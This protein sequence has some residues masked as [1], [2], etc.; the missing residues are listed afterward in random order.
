M[1]ESLSIRDFQR[2]KRLT[3]KFSRNV[4][5]IVGRSDAGKSAILRA[6]GWV[7]R[8]R[9]AGAAFVRRRAAR[10]KVALTV[11]GRIVV[12]Q[13]GKGN[14]YSL[15]GRRFVSFGNAVPD[16]IADLLNVADVNFQSQHD[17]PYLLAQSPGQVAKALNSVINL[18]IIDRS[19]ARA[20][21]AVR[22][23]TTEIAVTRGRL[24]KSKSDATSLAWTPDFVKGVERLE[25]AANQIA[26][27]RTTI[28]SL[29]S[30]IERLE[31]AQARAKNAAPAILDGQKIER[32]GKRWLANRERL[33]SLG[34]LIDRIEAA[35]VRHAKLE[36]QANRLA[37]ELKRRTKG[38]CPICKRPI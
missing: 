7:C 12:R 3:I 35:Q 8:N 22:K 13:R 9:P 23:T 28:D 26:A 24:K 36:R 29:A 31:S 38:I 17:A 25:K 21:A 33:E 30:V 27:K 18:G 34:E 1:L 32:I 16:P 2:H 5:T 20:A 14:T 10:A 19:L 15:D 11:D 4:T 37:A 6:L